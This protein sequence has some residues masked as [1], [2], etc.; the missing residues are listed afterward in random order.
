MNSLKV[1]RLF[2]IQLYSRVI[3]SMTVKEISLRLQQ[4]LVHCIIYSKIDFLAFTRGGVYCRNLH[5]IWK[6]R[7]AIWKSRGTIIS[8][9]TIQPVVL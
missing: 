8:Q 1:Q 4:V 5:P 7:G 2:R 9:Q 3:I 6:S